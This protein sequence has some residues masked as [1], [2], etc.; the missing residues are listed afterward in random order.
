M[1]VNHSSQRPMP[2][3]LHAFQLLLAFVAFAEQVAS[4][5]T[6]SF[7]R[8][9]RRHHRYSP[10]SVPLRSSDQ[11]D[12]AGASEASDGSSP[13]P[14]VVIFDL[15]GCLWVPEMYEINWLSGGKGSPFS[16][17]PDGT[18]LTC[19]GETVRLLGDV[20]EVMAELYGSP[21]WDGVAFGISSRTD[22]PE[23]A[24]ELLQKFAIGGSA[25]KDEHV[26][27]QDVFEGGPV[28]ISKDGKVQ[29]FQ[30]IAASL[31]VSFGDMLFFDNESGNCR[32]VARLGV[33]VGYCPDGVTRQIWDVSLEAF[34][35]TG[36]QVVGIDVIGYDTL[37]G[38]E[39]F[40]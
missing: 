33:T 19:G 39:R 18:L 15:D 27:L 38:A 40:Y 20:R 17:G 22:E 30:R 32:E 9:L 13:K 35:Q 12:N 2:L 11:S 25:G 26:F 8:A 36:G 31:G 14:K 28:E 21:A 29:H 4:F 7:P 24:R 1:H 34:P 37:E 16:E 10:L 3:L 6:S 5:A 23:W